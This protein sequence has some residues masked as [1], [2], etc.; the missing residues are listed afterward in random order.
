[1]CTEP[2]DLRRRAGWD[3]AS[4]ISRHQLLDALHGKSVV[5]SAR[6]TTYVHCTDYIPSAIMIP[7]RRFAALLQQAQ[8]LQRQRCKYHNPP[9]DARFSLYS[10][11][12]CSKDDFPRVTT[13]ILEVH[14]DEVWNLEWSHDGNY[15]ASAGKDKSAIIWRRGVSYLSPPFL[16][17]RLISRIVRQLL[18]P[19]LTQNGRQNISFEMMTM[20]LG[21]WRG[22]QMTRFCLQV[23]NI[24]S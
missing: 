24:L 12:R 6:Q 16:N 5:V 21:V 22:L 19:P 4:G 10:D 14:S 2:E 18:I 20:Q 13:T 23:Q 7:Q 15:L 3:G 1:M 11:H 17:F 9:P 8:D